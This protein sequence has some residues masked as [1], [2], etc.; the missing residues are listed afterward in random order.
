MIR[1][2]DIFTDG[3]TL[4]RQKPIRIWGHTDCPQTVCIALNGKVLVENEH[5]E[6]DFSLSLPAQ[7]AMSDA[8]LAIEGTNDRIEL[9]NVDIG[10]VWIAGG[11]SNMEFL[12]RYD[13]EASEQIRT[14]SDPHLRF[15]DVGE[16]TF[17]NEKNITC[18]DNSN[19]WDRWLS[20]NRET[21]EYF[22]AVGVYFARILRETYDVP[23]AIVGCN[24]GGT[25]ASAWTEES[26]LENDPVLRV[27]MDEYRKATENLDMDEY[28]QKH[29]EALA[30]LESKEMIR[31]MRRAMYGNISLPEYIRAIPV[32]MKISKAGMPI[33]PRYQNAPGVLYRTMVSRIAGFSC[34]GVIWY[35]GES[36]DTHAEIY[37]RL[38]ST[39]IRCWR[40]AWKEELPFL[41]VQLAPFGKWLGNTGE[42]YP[43]VRCKQEIVSKTVPGV[44]M[45]SIMDAGDRKDIH[46]KQKRPAG[47]RLAL[48][49]RGKV[50]HEDILCEAPE[51]AEAVVQDGR[52][53]LRFANA[54]EGLSIR[55]KRLNA[56]ELSSKDR[57][58]RWQKASVNGDLLIIEGK[59]IQKDKKLEVRY[60]WSS[61]CEANLYSS[62]GLCA[63]PFEWKYG[64]DEI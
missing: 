40:N 4:Q 3:M 32:L 50:Y 37:D 2:A 47:E 56:F 10:E 63:K 59:E 1:L 64:A 48:L 19:A 5:I 38:F 17:E 44:W 11:Q 7:Q 58:L 9:K 13:A 36:D 41:F 15:Y 42:M 21:A 45:A 25:T 6:E 33:G 49:A 18:K 24:W 14:A 54:G 46:P 31:I 22:S 53:V 27:Y 12:L 43:V 23:V 34:R 39:M 51:F 60:A 52:L 16:Y 35:Q 57:P 61:W 62:A 8:V 30:F 26:L 28:I 55:G 20:F 29:A